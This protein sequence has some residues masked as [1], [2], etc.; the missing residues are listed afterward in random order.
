MAVGVGRGVRV[1]ELVAVRVAVGW[2]VAVAV[3]PEVRVGDAVAVRVAVG[4]DSG[5]GSRPGGA[6]WGC[7]GGAG[8]CRPDGGGGS[9]PGGAGWG[10]SGGAGGC[11]PD[12]GGGSW[13]GGAGWGCSG[14]AGGCRPDSGGG[15]AGSGGR[16]WR[17][18][19]DEG[20]KEL[21]FSIDEIARDLHVGP[22]GVINLLRRR[23]VGERRI[24]GNI[25]TQKG[26]IG[27]PVDGRGQP[28]LE[29]NLLPHRL[30]RLILRLEAIPHVAQVD[31]VGREQSQGR[32]HCTF[33]EGR[34]LG[35]EDCLASRRG[36][37]ETTEHL[38]PELLAHGQERVGQGKGMLIGT[39]DGC[40][41]DGIKISLGVVG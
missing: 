1:G 38:I 11:G 10:C 41:H 27:P 36:L 19:V 18:R 4:P 34:G 23:V 22:R 30:P 17:P 39:I 26:A 31:V 16:S 37:I 2:I 12:S 9:R 3:G 13:P 35:D 40:R 25:A 6:G 15:P 28:L 20:G 5:G 8:G 21:P 24:I 7:S 33:F 14:G 32:V 29:H